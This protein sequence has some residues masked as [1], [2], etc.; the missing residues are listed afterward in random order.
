MILSV[1]KWANCREVT[2]Y[3]IITEDS[4]SDWYYVPKK[5]VPQ[6]HPSVNE[7]TFAINFNQL[8]YIMFF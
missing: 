8:L 2:P 1:L 7:L 3:N 4:F 5:D 6:V